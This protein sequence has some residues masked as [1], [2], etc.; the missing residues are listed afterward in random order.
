MY[1][2]EVLR[3]QQEKALRAIREKIELHLATAGEA[4]SAAMVVSLTEREARLVIEALT[5]LIKEYE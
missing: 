1:A 2:W 3:A 5:H 4:K